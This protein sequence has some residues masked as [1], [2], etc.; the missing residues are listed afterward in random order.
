MGHL[1]QGQSTFRQSVKS[2][3]GKAPDKA[4]TWFNFGHALQIDGNP[5]TEWSARTGFW[6]VEGMTVKNKKT[7]RSIHFA[8]ETPF[9]Q[10][11]I[12]NAIQLPDDHVIFQLG[13]EQICVLEPQTKRIALLDSGRGPAVVMK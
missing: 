11:M 5:D 1:A 8:W 3:Y 10:W 13:D 12:R 7:G 9:S 4:L 6:P 2:A